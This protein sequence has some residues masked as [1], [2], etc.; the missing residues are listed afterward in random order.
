MINRLLL[1]VQTIRMDLSVFY[2]YSF[3]YASEIQRRRVVSHLTYYQDKLQEIISYSSVPLPETCIPTPFS[4]VLI[5]ERV[6]G[7]VATDR[8]HFTPERYSSSRE[9]YLTYNLQKT[10]QLF[11]VIADTMLH[12]L[13]N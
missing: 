11:Q 12:C 7:L 9:F 1:C 13:Y 4:S 5:K 6:K 3:R 8:V 10:M 2:S